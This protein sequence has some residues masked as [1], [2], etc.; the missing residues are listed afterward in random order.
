MNHLAKSELELAVSENNRRIKAEHM[1]VFGRSTSS[2][3]PTSAGQVVYSTGLQLNRLLV[4]LRAI[5]DWFANPEPKIEK[6]A[7]WHRV[8]AENCVTSDALEFHQNQIEELQLALSLSLAD[9]KTS[10]VESAD[11]NP[12]RYNELG[13]SDI[14]SLAKSSRDFSHN[15]FV[16]CKSLAAVISKNVAENKLEGFEKQVSQLAAL[17]KKTMKAIGASDLGRLGVLPNISSD[18]YQ[19]AM[20]SFQTRSETVSTRAELPQYYI[21]ELDMLCEP[22]YMPF[23]IT[24]LSFQRWRV[25]MPGI[26]DGKL[27]PDGKVWAQLPIRQES[28]ALL[29]SKENLNMMRKALREVQV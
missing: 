1:R 24:V 11:Q 28:L 12:E 20:T 6:V 18:D 7:E 4:V 3:T 27:V 19:A 26:P 5:E 23:K 10:L 16:E 2:K 9:K 21:E 22:G 15:Y 13:R 14:K 17:L 29:S 8:S 25:A